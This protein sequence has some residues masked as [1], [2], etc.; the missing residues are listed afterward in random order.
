MTV[1]SRGGGGGGLRR[2]SETGDSMG[3]GKRGQIKF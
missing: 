2:G 3:M 1:R